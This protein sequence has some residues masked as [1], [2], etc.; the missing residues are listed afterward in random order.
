VSAYL[1]QVCEEFSRNMYVSNLSVR[2]SGADGLEFTYGH[3]SEDTLAFIASASKTFISEL[4]L[5]LSDA[6]DLELDEQLARYLSPSELAGLNRYRGQ[7]RSASI[8]IRQLLKNTS[9]IPDYYTEKRL[10]KSDDIAELTRRDPGWTFQESIAIAKSKRARFAPGQGFGYSFTNYQ[11]LSEVAE[12]ATNQSLSDLLRKQIF[13]P[14]GL[15]QTYLFTRQTL[16]SFGTVSPLKFGLQRYDG[17]RRM[18]SLRGEGGIVSST[19]DTTTFMNHFVAN[20]IS[21]YDEPPVFADSKFAFP[22][23][24]YGQGIMEIRL[25][26]VFSNFKKVPTAIGHLG[27][28]GYFMVYVPSLA[29]TLVGTVNQLARPLLGPALL[30]KLL[31]A[32]E[33]SLDK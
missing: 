23:V 6:G 33:K 9:G 7:D 20:R 12:R 28:T 14:L 27:A 16:A 17:A 21:P 15:S 18:A 2:A 11:V 1:K 30:A 26:R 4:F 13:E 5:Q 29:V 31:A 19:S 32:L 24:R 10:P 3:N 22:G 8:T 25:P